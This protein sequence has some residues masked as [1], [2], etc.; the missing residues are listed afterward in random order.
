MCNRNIEPLFIDNYTLLNDSRLNLD[1][2]RKLNDISKYLKEECSVLDIE[3][4]LLT[5][6]VINK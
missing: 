5:G 2:Y 6:K 1:E 3:I 4:D